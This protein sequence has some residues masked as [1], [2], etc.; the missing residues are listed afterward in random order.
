VARL[1]LG[2]QEVP[3]TYVVALRERGAV[4]YAS[5]PPGASGLG[6]WPY[7]RP[8]AVDHLDASPH[9]FA[10]IHQAVHAEGGHEIATSIDEVRVR[11]VAAL[12]PWFGTALA[13]DELTGHGALEATSAEGGGTWALVEGQLLRGDAGVAAE[14]GAQALVALPEPAGLVH[15]LVNTEAIFA[16]SGWAGLRWRSGP[17]GRD[18][19]R[20]LVCSDWAEIAVAQDGVWEVV[21]EG[22]T[23]LPAAHL[24][25]LQ[26][27]DDGTTMGAHL[28]GRL[29][30]E[31]WITDGRHAELRHVGM[32]VGPGD[33][34]SLRCFEAHGRLVMVPAELDLGATWD[35][36]GET[37]VIDDPFDGPP[38]ELATA[39]LTV[40]GVALDA[41]AATGGDRPGRPRWVRSL[42][43]GHLDLT[44]ETSLKVRA[45]RHQPN[46]G[47]TLYTVAWDD[48]GFADLEVDVLPPGTARSQ[49]Q[50][51]RGGL[52][53]W[54]DAGSYLVLNVWVDDSPTHNG[55]AVSMFFSSEGHDRTANAIWTNI[56]RAVTWGVRSTL[57]VASDGE[58][59]LV[60]LDGE[61]VLYRRL[62]DLYPTAPRLSIARVGLAVNREWGDDTGTTFFDFVARG[63]R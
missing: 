58:H 36:R 47:R 51:S 57:R 2:V 5:G 46:Q 52:V 27:T 45:D 33:R 24:A 37:V 25:S 10:G 54:Q 31:R 17:D 42:G 59:V 14:H 15:V 8:L 53:F 4:Y 12:R 39:G 38:G 61:P 32:A 55:S 63:R 3:V 16:E 40:G 11:E 44:G 1:H 26:V 56:G 30:F 60:R 35:E 28:D 41:G 43:P 29:L 50:G 9:V 48:P 22:P 18:G 21:A 13:A 49:G 34:A 20:V 19:W 6:P 7:L 62:R 23:H